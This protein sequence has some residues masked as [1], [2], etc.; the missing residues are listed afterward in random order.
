M[1]LVDLIG[2]KLEAFET[3]IEDKLHAL[4]AKFI[5]GRSP[6]P[7]RSQQSEIP[8]HKENPLEKEECKIDL[9]PTRMRVDFPRWEDGDSTGWLSH[10]ERYFLYH[11]TPE[12]SMMDITAIHLEGDVIQWYNYFEHTHRVLTWREFKSGLFVLVTGALQANHVSDGTCDSFFILIFVAHVILPLRFPN[13]GIRAKRRQRGGGAASHGQPPC[14]AGHPWLGHSK[15]PRKEATGCDQGQPAREAGAA[16]G[17]SSPQGRRLRARIEPTKGASCRAPAGATA[18]RGHTR[19]QPGARKGLPPA[20]NPVTNRGSG[21]DRRG[22]RPLA[23]WLPAGKGSSDDDRDAD[24]AEGLGH[25]FE[26][27][28]IMPL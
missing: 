6:S 1:A 18:A 26:K 23:G 22:G 19:L 5:L 11:R 25:P 13:S 28:T 7:T 21:A 24:G 3:C 4:F 9:A 10:V 16:R 8:N 15:G 27:R 14:R 12:I 20:A 2:A 17:G